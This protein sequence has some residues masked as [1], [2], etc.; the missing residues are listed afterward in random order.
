MLE[1]TPN[2]V[3]ALV[4]MSVFLASIMGVLVVVTWGEESQKRR[5]ASRR[6]RLLYRVTLDGNTYERFTIN[7][8][9]KVYENDHGYEIWFTAKSTGLSCAVSAAWYDLAELEPEHGETL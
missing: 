3:Q 4:I 7:G 1:F 8:R 5:E 2:E 6:F 9:P